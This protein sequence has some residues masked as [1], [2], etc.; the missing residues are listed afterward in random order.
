MD[1]GKEIRRRK[2]SLISGIKV[3]LPFGLSPNTQFSRRAL[4]YA[5]ET[6]LNSQKPKET[7]KPNAHSSPRRFFQ[8]INI[9]D[10]FRKK[11][12]PIIVPAEIQS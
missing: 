11:P 8:G 4:V 5:R 10:L 9:N 12:E 6:Y 7:R 3:E 1:K 2:V